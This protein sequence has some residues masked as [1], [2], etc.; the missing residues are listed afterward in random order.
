MR[1][2]S[3]RLALAIGA[4]YDYDKITLRRPYHPTPSPRLP[5]SKCLIPSASQET[6]SWVA[7]LYL[8]SELASTLWN[9][10]YGTR[11]LEP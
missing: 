1:L 10:F 3:R 4:F 11:I 7:F 9:L 5:D 6:I 8:I 2:L